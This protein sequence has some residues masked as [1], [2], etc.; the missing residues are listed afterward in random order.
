MREF[1]DRLPPDLRDSFV[2]LDADPHLNADIAWSR[3]D[4]L[5]VLEVL[6]KERLAVA[7]GDVCARKDGA[8]TYTYDNW[9]C[10]PIK[11]ER[12]EVY[13]PR[14]ITQ[15]LDYIKR[16]PER[17]GAVVMYVIT[18]SDGG[19][20][21]RVEMMRTSSTPTTRRRTLRAFL[22]RMLRRTGG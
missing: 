5:K 19:L 9:S 10:E 12:F 8:L 21:Q 7:G 6:Q 15:A 18:A 20:F 17:E 22:R 4:A 13:A 16:Y 2:P 1:L 14:S 11:N 3:Q